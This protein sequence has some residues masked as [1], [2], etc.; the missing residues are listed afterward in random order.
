[1]IDCVEVG[2]ISLSQSYPVVPLVQCLQPDSGGK[3]P[4][5]LP[6]QPQSFTT[7]NAVQSFVSS[8]RSSISAT[9]SPVSLTVSPSLRT[10]SFLGQS[11]TYSFRICPPANQS[12]REHN[13]SG[14]SLPGGFTLIQLP[15]PGAGGAAGQSEPI[16]MTTGSGVD[17]ALTQKAVADSET[18]AKPLEARSFSD[19]VCNE[20][21]PSDDSDDSSSSQVKSNLDFASEDL[22]SNSSDDSGDDDVSIT[23]TRSSTKVVL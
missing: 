15:K 7:M 18:K 10:P 4:V 19:L 23:N 22:S 12:T 14:V 1:M 13:P 8:Q 3:G 21:I 6:Q 17:K 16:T 20:K 5:A 11:G 2:V 9:P